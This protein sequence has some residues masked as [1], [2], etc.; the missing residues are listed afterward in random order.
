M[1]CVFVSA[2]VSII[3]IFRPF[4][5]NFIIQIF[6]LFYCYCAIFSRIFHRYKRWKWT[7]LWHY[8]PIHKNPGPEQV[9]KRKVQFFISPFRHGQGRWH[10]KKF[11][12]WKWQCVSYTWWQQRTFH[13]LVLSTW[14]LILSHCV[15]VCEW[16]PL[17]AVRTMQSALCTPTIFPCN[18]MCI[19]SGVELQAM[20]ATYMQ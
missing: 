7:A 20:N 17:N 15:C 12:F 19:D 8:F 13:L 11:F 14:N 3:I 9:A 6:M 4:E 18:A 1:V 5:I 16:R 10:E 2:T